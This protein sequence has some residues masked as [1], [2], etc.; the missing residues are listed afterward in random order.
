LDFGD[1]PASYGT[2]LADDGARHGIPGYDPATNSA[3]VMLG[4]NTIDPETDGQPSPLADGDDTNGVNDET[5]VR[6]NPALGYLNPTL[7][8]GLDPVSL[9]P[10]ENTL[11][12]DAS[13]DGFVSVWVDW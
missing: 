5:G 8:T 7:R 12:I 9:Q 3:P 6:F 2:L 11:A 1:A 13:A 4:T 10:V